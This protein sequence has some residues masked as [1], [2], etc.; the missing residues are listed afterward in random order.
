MTD[1]IPKFNFMLKRKV[2]NYR[3]SVV[4]MAAVDNKENHL[5]C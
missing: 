3:H 1:T 2:N 5:Q 4:T